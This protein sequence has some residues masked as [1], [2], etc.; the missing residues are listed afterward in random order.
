MPG[1]LGTRKGGAAGDLYAAASYPF[2]GVTDDFRH[3]GRGHRR[4]QRFV[5]I[6]QMLKIRTAEA[7]LAGLA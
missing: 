1:F 4:G 2:R 3:I 5:F 6:G 7:E